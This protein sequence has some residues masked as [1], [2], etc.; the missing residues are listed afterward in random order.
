M[1]WTWKPDWAV[2]PA[3]IGDDEPQARALFEAH[4]AET[5]LANRLPAWEDLHE[6][7]REAWRRE[8]RNP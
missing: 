7:Q 8:L 5:I 4:V 2:E 1:G 3:P 6:W